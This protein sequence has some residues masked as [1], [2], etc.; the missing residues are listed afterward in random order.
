[1]A[2]KVLQGM[3]VAIVCATDFEQSEM[4]EPRRALQEAGAST[5][6]VSLEPG[7]ARREEG[8]IQG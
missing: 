4:T 6:L 3:R 7:A 5:V 2:D 1:M 8:Q